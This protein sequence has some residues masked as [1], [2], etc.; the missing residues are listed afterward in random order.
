[1]SAKNKKSTRSKTNSTKANKKVSAPRWLIAVVL[2]I[3]VATGGFLVYKS[4]AIGTDPNPPVG[5]WCKYQRAFENYGCRIRGG[6]VYTVYNTVNIRSSGA[7]SSGKQYKNIQGP[8]G[9]Q[10]PNWYCLAV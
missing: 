7:C 1:M 10:F 8:L 4:F 9:K 6:G 2:V 5:V 3:V